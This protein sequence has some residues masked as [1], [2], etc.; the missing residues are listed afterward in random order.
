[1]LVQ[2]FAKQNFFFIFMWN[3]SQKQR[4]SC[5]TPVVLASRFSVSICCP[6]FQSSWLNIL[7]GYQSGYLL[8]FLCC[9]LFC[10]NWKKNN[11]QE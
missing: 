6:H 11:I 2:N 1:M 3:L 4:Q 8:I 5:W 10:V 9:Q 7:T